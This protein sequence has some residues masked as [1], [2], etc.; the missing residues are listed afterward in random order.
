MCL[1]GICKTPWED[2]YAHSQTDPTSNPTSVTES[3]PKI[4]D[5]KSK[6]L[7]ELYMKHLAMARSG[8]TTYLKAARAHQDDFFRLYPEHRINAYVGEYLSFMGVLGE[9]IDRK[10]MTEAEAEYELAKKHTELVEKSG[11]AARQQQVQGE[12]TAAQQSAM[13]EQQRGLAEQKRKERG[14]MM[15]NLGL[16]ILQWNHEQGLA[17]QMG[18]QNCIWTRTMNGGYIQNCQ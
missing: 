2:N 14:A 1:G 4:E 13:A 12:Q 17:A 18:R 7:N 8:E 15:Y 9:K 5:E 11:Q 6:E 3:N 10:L 16:Q